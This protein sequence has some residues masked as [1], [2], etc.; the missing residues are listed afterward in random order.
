MNRVNPHTAALA[1]ALFW[2]AMIAAGCKVRTTKEDILWTLY[3]C[4]TNADCV[5]GWA[6]RKFG[7]DPSDLKYCVKPCQEDTD[8]WQ[9]EFCS[10]EGFCTQRCDVADPHCHSDGLTC[11]RMNMLEADTAGY[12]QPMPT[13]SASAD[14]N[15]IQDQCVGEIAADLFPGLA[16]ASSDGLCVQSC[17]LGSPCSTG[18][19]C[20]SE[21][22]SEYPIFDTLPELCVPRCGEANTCPNGTRCVID[23]LKE[24]HP[25]E[26]FPEGAFRFCVPGVPIVEMPCT[27]DLD[28]M[29]GRCVEHPTRNLPGGG[30]LFI[31][32]LPCEAG[33]T[34]WDGD[35]VCLGTTYHG[36]WAE[37]CFRP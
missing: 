18:F 23:A 10:N 26:Q 11:M 13:C 3:Q 27:G 34:C 22:S 28:C 7:M 31:C 8:C 30:P 20:V 17:A 29:L 5:D 21:V 16:I 12:C 2:C 33:G 24:L 9:E 6:C 14:C 32:V 25:T 35:A 37:F 15:Q 1:G 4:D 19:V 36:E